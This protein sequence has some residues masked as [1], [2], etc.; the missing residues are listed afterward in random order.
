MKA[1]DFRT[2]KTSCVYNLMEKTYDNE[3][4]QDHFEGD[5]R[6]V[7][8]G[9]LVRLNLPALGGASRLVSAWNSMVRNNQWSSRATDKNV[10]LSDLPISKASRKILG[11]IRAGRINKTTINEKYSKDILDGRELP[12]YITALYFS[13][14]VYKDPVARFKQALASVIGDNVVNKLI[15]ATAPYAPL[16]NLNTFDVKIHAD[17]DKVKPVDIVGIPLLAKYHDDAEDGTRYVPFVICQNSVAEK[18]VK[19]VAGY[20]KLTGRYS[21]NTPQGCLKHLKKIYEATEICWFV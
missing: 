4:K 20:H 21:A 16:E 15:P 1:E 8:L 5:Y 17:L 14:Q 19:Y 3:F 18:L 13:A 6:L 7:T 12:N 11:D 9:V 10:S 2:F